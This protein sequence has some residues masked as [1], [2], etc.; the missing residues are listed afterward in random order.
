MDSQYLIVGLGNSGEAYR[1]TRHN[2]GFMVLDKLAAETNS[3]FSDC[4]KFWIASSKLCQKNRLLMKPSTYMNLSGIAVSS[5][6]VLY[7]IALSNLIVICDDFNLP[8][9]TIRIRP[10]GS[11]GGQNGLR[12]IISEIGTNEFIRVRIGIGSTMQNSADYVL[13]NFTDDEQSKL[14]ELINVARDSVRSLIENGI[15][16]SMNQYNGNHLI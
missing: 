8:F 6:L 11:D 2:L 1:K 15:V 12:S 9:G 13:S 16:Y 4:D 7:N 3:H 10:K 5:G 14:T